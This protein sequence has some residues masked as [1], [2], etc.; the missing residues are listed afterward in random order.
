MMRRRVPAGEPRE[1]L[2]SVMAMWRNIEIDDLPAWFYWQR[3]VF[4]LLRENFAHVR[5]ARTV[6]VGAAFTRGAGVTRRHFLGGT[7]RTRTRACPRRHSRHAAPAS[8][9]ACA[10]IDAQVAAIFFEYCKR[11]ANGSKGIA[12]SFSMSSRE[13]VAFCK[14]CC[15]ARATHRS[16]AQ[17]ETRAPRACARASVGRT[18]AGGSRAVAVAPRAQ[19]SKIPLNVAEVNDTFRRV[20]RGDGR[21]GSSPPKR[22]APGRAES[23][24]PKS[25]KQLGL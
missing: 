10:A 20:D 2:Q 22:G 16:C 25:D 12:Q 13:F 8:L 3:G 9:D 6:V 24:K 17:R 1:Q 14:V 5:V 21:I 15:C 23:Q 7:A 4:E 18:R 11:G 19:E